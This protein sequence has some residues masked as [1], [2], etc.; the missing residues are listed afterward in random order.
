MV[1]GKKI[2]FTVNAGQMV[3]INNAFFGFLGPGFAVEDF[4]LPLLRYASRQNVKGLYI[5]IGN[6]GTA[7]GDALA[8]VIKIKRN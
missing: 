6:C 1:V 4:N 8:P 2:P 3:R 7:E 5:L